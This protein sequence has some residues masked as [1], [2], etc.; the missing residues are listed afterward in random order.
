MIVI[1]SIASS[2]LLIKKHIFT[3]ALIYYFIKASHDFKYI[4]I[5]NFCLIVAVNCSYALLIKGSPW[6]LKRW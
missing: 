2:A 5:P 6:A 4:H 1:F 3:N